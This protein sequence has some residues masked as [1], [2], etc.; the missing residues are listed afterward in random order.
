M[1]GASNGNVLKP[2]QSMQFK[3]FK[4]N[5]SPGVAIRHAL[6]LHSISLLVQYTQIPTG[7]Q[8]LMNFMPKVTG[9]M[10]KKYTSYSSCF[11]LIK[12]LVMLAQRTQIGIST[13]G[14]I[15]F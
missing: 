12:D 1:W 4:A 9:D 14:W 7:T 13:R 2:L 11:F 6:D 8:K 3:V 15:F 5:F 10:C